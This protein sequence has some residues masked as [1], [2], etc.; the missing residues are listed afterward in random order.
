VFFRHGLTTLRSACTVTFADNEVGTTEW[1]S[2]MIQ[3]ASNTSVVRGPHFSALRALLVPLVLVGTLLSGLL[4]F[5]GDASAASVRQGARW[6]HMDILLSRQETQ[7]VARGIVGG[8]KVC[9]PLAGATAA[10]GARIGGPYGA[11]IGAF[12][13]GAMC[14]TAVTV[15]AARANSQGRSAGFTVSPA[16]HGLRY[17]CWSY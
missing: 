7:D 5:P 2:D 8:A 12:A 9:W 17:W 1:E 3:M 10:L 14:I 13:G 6:D 15:C 11:A 16:W 4:A